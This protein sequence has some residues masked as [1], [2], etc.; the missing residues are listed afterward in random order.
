MA[1]PINSSLL[2][3]SESSM[4]PKYLAISR[5]A[6]WQ[7]AVKDP[8]IQVEDHLSQLPVEIAWII[9]SY[10]HPDQVKEIRLLSK[11]YN[12]SWRFD[13]FNFGLQNLLNLRKRSKTEW[14]S[15]NMDLLSINHFAA[16]LVVTSPMIRMLER[17]DDTC[18]MG[19]VKV[20]VDESLYSWNFC[21]L[22]RRRFREALKIAFVAPGCCMKVEVIDLL[23]FLELQCPVLLAKAMEMCK[24]K[25][26]ESIEDLHRVLMSACINS[27]PLDM[28][29]PIALHP[30]MDADHPYGLQRALL[31][32]SSQC[33]IPL[34]N[35]FLS[36]QSVSPAFN[37]NMILRVTCEGG[38]PEAVKALLQ[39]P[40]TDPEDTDGDHP[41]AI[42]CQLGRR[43]IVKILLA[44]SRTR[45]AQRSLQLL[46]LAMD[47]KIIKALLRHPNFDIAMAGPPGLTF[48]VSAGNIKAV[49][50]L[51]SDSRINPGA[52]ENSALYQ[53]VVHCHKEIVKLLL[54]DQRVNAADANNRAI[55]S[56]RS[57]EILEFLLK[58]PE[59][60]PSARENILFLHLLHD[61]D[62]PVDIGSKTLVKL[63]MK[64]VPRMICPP[65]LTNPSVTNITKM[66][67]MLL[68]DPRFN[69]VTPLNL[70]VRLAAKFGNFTV[71]KRLLEFPGIHPGANE[72]EA[73]K[74]ACAVRSLSTVQ[75]LLADKRVNPADNDMEALSIACMPRPDIRVVRE[76]LKGPRIN[77]MSR[78]PVL[79]GEAC[80]R[81]EADLVAA[82]LVY[83]RYDPRWGQQQ[84]FVMAVAGG[85]QKVVEI[86]LRDPRVDP[87]AQEN[88]AFLTAVRWGRGH[89]LEVLLADPRIPT[90]LL[91][92][93]KTI[94]ALEGEWLFMF[95][96]PI[97]PPF[98]KSIRLAARKALR[99]S[100]RPPLPILFDEY[101]ID[102]P[103]SSLKYKAMRLANS[104]YRSGC[105][106]CGNEGE[107]HSPLIENFEQMDAFIERLMGS[108]IPMSMRSERV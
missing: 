65:S 46:L 75:L 18:C 87:C 31:L 29:R 56:A 80:G 1:D 20:Y 84:A 95:V 72:N 79:L 23:V 78:G 92:H 69:P 73:L 98:S 34:M 7:N 30:E 6:A 93:D 86:M 39:D 13:S 52:D 100:R 108:A 70:P 3:S 104:L 96:N 99:L 22:H 38:S 89:V 11:H 85:H 14:T 27:A 40:R 48:H 2:L 91:Y 33:N 59:V 62:G 60:R 12:S 5:L 107:D 94:T 36:I 8:P 105:P 19:H 58:R 17:T 101:G 4:T 54:S 83:G 50:V 63:T 61:W 26:Q 42:A 97:C 67:D 28:V 77:A 41:L 55:I 43:D 64:D 15:V 103:R 16:Y 102:L 68:S 10:L 25:S 106:C 88:E 71:V 44:D 51:L 66:M 47:P 90:S 74:C 82:L 81:G 53:A 76:L 45:V 9:A 24:F 49:K 21:P 32:V 37:S 57:A 35:L